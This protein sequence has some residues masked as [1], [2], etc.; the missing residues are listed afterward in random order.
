MATLKPELKTILDK[1]GINPNDRSQVWD[2]RGTLVLYHKAFEIISAKEGIWFD[3]PQVIRADRDEAVL[4]VVGHMGDDREEWSFGEAVI[5]LNYKVS[6]NQAGYPWAMAEKRAK[7]RVIAKLVGLS[8]YIHSE[9]EADSFMEAKPDTREEAPTSPP[10]P[11]EPPPPDP[12]LDE[13]RKRVGLMAK[14]IDGC[15][16]LAA[17]DKVM[18]NYGIEPNGKPAPD[19]ALYEVWQAKPE[20]F[21]FL[22]KKAADK[23][24]S[25]NQKQAAE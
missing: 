17:L 8:A 9:E 6:G 10:P 13:L 23:R 2:C 25:F 24:A 21:D 11:P 22:M 4:L 12:S 1:Y 20:G 18:S 16:S 5:G 19:T 14:A 7:D 3:P 15:G